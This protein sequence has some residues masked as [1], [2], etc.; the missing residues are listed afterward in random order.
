MGEIKSTL[1]LV[2]EKTKGLTL[3]EKEKRQRKRQEKNDLLRGLL[4]KYQ[5]R[6][7]NLDQLRKEFE[8]LKRGI[9]GMDGLMLLQTFSRIQPGEDNSPLISV[10]RDIF[11]LNVARLESTLERY[12]NSIRKAAEYRTAE[13]RKDLSQIQ[14][15]QGS[16]VVPNL[17][18]DRD[19]SDIKEAIRSEYADI[20]DREKDALKNRVSS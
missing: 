14:L 1:E 2:M 6:R 10:L 17:E 15:I 3:S 12:E 18:V 13:I 20:L 8:K 19:W 11:Q 16:A 4:Q 9:E 5:D 7:L